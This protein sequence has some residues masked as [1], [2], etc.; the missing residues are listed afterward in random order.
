MRSN[1]HYGSH[2]QTLTLGEMK[3]HNIFF[4]RQQLF[5]GIHHY[6]HELYSSTQF[7]RYASF[8]DSVLKVHCVERKKKTHCRKPFGK[9]G[10]N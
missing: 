1:A 7:I 4:W 9:H 10:L 8:D 3:P 6:V 2:V 5:F